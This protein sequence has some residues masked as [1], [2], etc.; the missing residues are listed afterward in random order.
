MRKPPSPLRL[1]CSSVHSDGGDRPAWIALPLSTAPLLVASK[2][3]AW[4]YDRTFR[5]CAQ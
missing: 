4:T 2:G 1:S 3:G 5:R